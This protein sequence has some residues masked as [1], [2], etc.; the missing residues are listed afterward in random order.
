MEDFSI[1]S[2]NILLDVADEEPLVIAFTGMADKLHEMF[3]EWEGS[4]R[5]GSRVLVRDPYQLWF[6]RNLKDVEELLEHV[7]FEYNPTTITCIG[8]SAGGYA[9]IYFGYKAYY[10]DKVHA[11]GPQ[12][13]LSRGLKHYEGKTNLIHD[14]GLPCVDLRDLLVNPED[15]S[16]KYKIHIGTEEEDAR[17]A[18]HLADCPNVELVRYP[19]ETH[20]C[21]SQLLKAEG[22]LTEV[23]LST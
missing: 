15:R 12:A 2:P 1:D 20:A 14:E 3:F 16:T 6:Q 11:F 18:E 19:C 10:V 8:A 7:I 21:A 23:I 17:H 22:R 13:F 5:G 4:T 9:A